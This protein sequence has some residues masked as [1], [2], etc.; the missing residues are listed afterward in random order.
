[1]KAAGQ[2]GKLGLTSDTQINSAYKPDT[3]YILQAAHAMQS[4]QHIEIKSRIT[5]VPIL[6]TK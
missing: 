2:R 4:I 6:L 1:M 5:Q 3:F